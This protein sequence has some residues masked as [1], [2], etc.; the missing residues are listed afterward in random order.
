VPHKT[1]AAIAYGK[2]V[3]SWRPDAGVKFADDEFAGDG[4]KQSPV[5]GE[6]AE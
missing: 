4:G 6:S 2:A 3:W 5:T 1:N